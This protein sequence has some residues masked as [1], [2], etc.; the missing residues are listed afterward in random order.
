MAAF[1]LLAQPA[2]VLACAACYGASD[3]PMAKGMNWGIFS[4]MAVVGMVLGC[5]ATFFVF[6][7][8]KS[9]EASSLPEADSQ[10]K[11]EPTEKI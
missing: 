9:A 5:I 3:S 11:T 6:I 8:K 10:K 1:V 4:L 7:G 2:S